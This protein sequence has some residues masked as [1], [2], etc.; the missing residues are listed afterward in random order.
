MI[1]GTWYAC[2]LTHDNTKAIRTLSGLKRRGSNLIQRNVCGFTPNG[3][4]A[5]LRFDGNKRNISTSILIG[6]SLSTLILIIILSEQVQMKQQILRG[7]LRVRCGEG[8]DANDGLGTTQEVEVVTKAHTSETISND[9]THLRNDDWKRRE[10]LVRTGAVTPLDDLAG[11]S[12]AVV[13]KRARMTLMDHKIAEGMN[14]E[15]PRP[16]RLSRRARS[17]GGGQVEIRPVS[18]KEHDAT[19][20]VVGPLS[21]DEDNVAGDDATTP[22]QLVDGDSWACQRCTL[23][24]PADAGECLACGERR[25]RKRNTPEN[26]P[27]SYES[28]AVDGTL[29]LGSSRIEAGA[30]TEDTVECPVCRQSVSVGDHT[31]PDVSLS[32]HMDR[33]TRLARRRP[34]EKT[35]DEDEH[36]DGNKARPKGTPR[37][38]TGS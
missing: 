23:V 33:C 37:H 27:S 31:N 13:P 24:C 3:A 18:G 30:L 5:F 17:F 28:E 15:L 34:L 20:A 35:E 7:L 9:S 26:A 11:I 32:K 4:Q 19:G 16:R 10:D 8:G 29:R 38:R 1:P 36:E 21:S 12:G 25:P 22:Q 2:C 14:V 6:L